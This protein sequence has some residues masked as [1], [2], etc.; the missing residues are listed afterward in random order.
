[1]SRSR[2]IITLLLVAL[3]T[4][5]SLADY[6]ATEFFAIETSKLAKLA[7]T[8]KELDSLSRAQLS[9]LST[10][11]GWYDGGRSFSF[12]SSAFR[13]YANFSSSVYSNGREP[14]SIEYHVDAGTGKKGWD[15]LQM[16]GVA[17]KQGK[18]FIT[19][20]WRAQP[21]I[22]VLRYLDLKR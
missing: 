4:H 10:A 6:A 7:P 18:Q 5:A 1:M 16:D 2:F 3:Q 22:V 20:D 12:S 8:D 19:K 14:A 21:F 13:L 17:I 15:I 9:E 11:K